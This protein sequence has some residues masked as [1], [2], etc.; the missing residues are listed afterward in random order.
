MIT[1]EN[2]PPMTPSN[3]L[4]IHVVTTVDIQEFL[5][6]GNSRI[7]WKVKVEYLILQMEYLTYPNI[8]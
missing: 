4:Y 1:Y 6:H 7:F 8:C 3:V 2:L 5:E